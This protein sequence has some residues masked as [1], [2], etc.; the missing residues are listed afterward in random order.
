[1]TRVFP[2][3]DELAGS[4][5]NKRL[6]GLAEERKASAGLVADRP[7][8]SVP[9]IERACLAS[10][11]R[12]PEVCVDLALAQL[13]G[14]NIFYSPAHR[15]I[16]DAIKTLHGDRNIRIDM[17]SVAQYLRSVLLL[18]RRDRGARLEDMTLG[19]VGCGHVGSKVKAVK[20]MTVGINSLDVMAITTAPNVEE[21]KDELI[22]TCIEICKEINSTTHLAV[23]RRYLRT[24]WLHE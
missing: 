21:A 20:G 24:V 4:P 19:L 23:W 14:D 7:Q 22:N 13:H 2:G 11:L 3:E 16:F 1:M 5:V 18:L 15:A 10:M 17:L 8:P 6:L 9:D 12:D